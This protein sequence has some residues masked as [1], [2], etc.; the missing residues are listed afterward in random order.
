VNFGPEQA[1]ATSP[2]AMQLTTSDAS[3]ARRPVLIA[4]YGPN[5]GT[6][7]PIDGEL[8]IGRADDAT[9]PV[10]DDRV[11]RRHTRVVPRGPEVVHVEDLGSKNGTWVNG[12]RVD[13]A[14]LRNG[15]TIQVGNEVVF[16]FVYRDPIEQRL[17]E[18]QK[19][20]AIG[21]LAGGVAHEF[22]NLLTVMLGNLT[23][24]QRELHAGPTSEAQRDMLR[25]AIGAAERATEMTGQ[26]L[27]LARRAR[28][29]G[30]PVDVSA[31][32]EDLGRLVGRT[33]VRDIR[34]VLDVMPGLH[35]CGQAPEL[36]QALLNLCI[37]ARDA[38]ASGGVLTLRVRTLAANDVRR[39]REGLPRGD[40]VELRV[41]DT[42]IG[43]D[44]ETLKH[45]FEPFFTTK[46]L[47]DG[48]GLGMAIVHG[49][50]RGHGGHIDVQ[51][52]L[53]RGSSISLLLPAVEAPEASA[54]TPEPEPEPTLAPGGRILLVEDDEALRRS[55]TRMLEH[56]DQR[57]IAV[58][59]GVEAV[60]AFREHGANIDLVVLDVSMPR[61]GGARTFAELRAL[62]PGVKVL[63]SSGHHHD[64]LEPEL[65]AGIDGFLPKPYTL[66]QLVAALRAI[67]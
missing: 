29:S 52:E 16:H 48:T 41:E 34:V 39:A 26:L 18:R 61:Q 2:A 60:G 7:Y 63:L 32:V 38:M 66:Q 53:G 8:V 17:L 65:R 57:V 49:I 31:L 36:Q 47:K 24:L 59:D 40:Y 43:M 46:G 6:E 15:D 51:S 19:L 35:V 42:G 25:D 20:E 10:Q 44:P 1:R 23:Q 13:I 54:A 22:N 45:V 67:A 30:L 62:A 56:L 33:L 3:K 9:I 5:P 14:E 21:R 12:R 64:H 50:V 27:G 11:S 58:A 28:P 37:N 4:L 55:V